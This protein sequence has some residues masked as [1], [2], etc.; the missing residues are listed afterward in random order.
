MFWIKWQ[1]TFKQYYIIFSSIL[2]KVLKIFLQKYLQ[3]ILQQKTCL[4]FM[5]IYK[6]FRKLIGN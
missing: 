4:K 3:K 6:V 1:I 5:K 2:R